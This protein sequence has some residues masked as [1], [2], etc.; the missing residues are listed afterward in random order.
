MFFQPEIYSLTHYLLEGNHK[1][2]WAKTL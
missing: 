2:E 1:S